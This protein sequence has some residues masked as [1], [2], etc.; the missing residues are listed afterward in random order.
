MFAPFYGTLK[1]SLH[2]YD[3]IGSWH[4]EYQVGVVRHCHKTQKCGSPGDSVILRGP[5]HD[6]EVQLFLFVVLAVTEANIE[7]YST[8][9][10][11]RASG[12]DSMKGTICRLEEL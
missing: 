11:I 8:Q 7:C 10:V 4:F 5:V 6:F 12:Y 9:W 3:F 2:S 1:A